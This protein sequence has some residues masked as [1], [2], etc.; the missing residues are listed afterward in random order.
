MAFTNSFAISSLGA[1]KIE[2][3]VITGGTKDGF[4][5]GF[6]IDG[7]P[8]NPTS[9]DWKKI[10]EAEET[11][12]IVNQFNG[13]TNQPLKFLS[14]DELLDEYDKRISDGDNNASIDEDELSDDS[15]II[16][17]G[18]LQK[19]NRLGPGL[20]KFKTKKLTSALAYPKDIDKNQDYLQIDKYEY[21]PPQDGGGANLKNPT[22]GKKYGGTIIL[23]MPKVS[24]SNAA[25]WGESYL[26]AFGLAAV[27]TVGAL[28]PG[29]GG[30]GL[31]LGRMAQNTGGMAAIAL[32]QQAAGFLSSKNINIDADQLLART[33]GNIIN[34]N[35]ELL[36]SGVTLRKFGFSYKL[37]ARSADEGANIRRII[38]FFKDGMVPRIVA[39][40]SLLGTPHIF[41]LQYKTNNDNKS[42][43]KFKDMALVEFKADYAPDGFWTA[44]EDSHPVAI[45]IH[46]GFSELQPIYD[47]DQLLYPAD[48]VG[49]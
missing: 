22:R 40:N 48:D 45:Q 9:N 8:V 26:N 39:G 20:R 34:P 42:V 6:F 23:P 38:K 10:A 47:V 35:A 32:A 27:G 44:Y 28:I 46:F 29:G 24:D 33:T 36:F 43:N 19:E 2:V 49:Y 18:E 12:F 17:G 31:D 1:R 14:E 16:I 30:E 25:V 3:D 7:I 37:V 5:T 21:R 13:T 41:A 15:G 11:K 4:I